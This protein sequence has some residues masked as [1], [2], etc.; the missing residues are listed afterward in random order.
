[1][2]RP[3]YKRQDLRD[4]MSVQGKVNTRSFGWLLRR[5]R[6]R[7]IDGWSIRVA[8]GKDR[9]DTNTYYLDG[10]GGQSRQA[11]EEEESM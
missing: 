5:H 10:P 1:M 8:S 4:V 6:D 11:Q 7:I 3:R 9:K 2:G